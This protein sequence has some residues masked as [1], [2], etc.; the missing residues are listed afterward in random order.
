MK[1]TSSMRSSGGRKRRQVLA[2]GPIGGPRVGFEVGQASRKARDRVVIGTQPRRELVPR[3]RHGDRRLWRS[4]RRERGD[5]GR[6]A[7]VPQVVDEDLALSFRLG[8]TGH[9]RLGFRVLDVLGQTAGI[10][11]ALVRGRARAQRHDDVQPFAAGGLQEALEPDRLWTL[12]DQARCVGDAA[13]LDAGAGVEIEHDAVR[14]LQVL[15][16]RMPRV[17]FEYSD[18][19][20]A[21]QCRERIDDEIFPGLGLFLDLHPA[22]GFGSPGPAVLLIEARSLR[23]LGTADERR[24]TILQVGQDPLRDALVEARQVELGRALRWKEDAVGVREP[25]AG[26]DRLDRRRD[27]LE[28]S[29]A[30][31]A[32]GS[33]LEHVELP[34]R[35]R[36]TVAMLDQEPATLIAPVPTSAADLREHP[37]TVELRSLERELQ[38]ANSVSR[39]WVSLGPPGAAV[40]QNDRA[41][42]IL[43]CRD[44]ALEARV[45][46][47][48]ILHLHRQALVGG[49]EAWTLGDRPALEGAVELETEIVVQP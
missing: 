36:L 5:A 35:A 44:G 7:R 29:S 24:R 22:D 19:D 47:R 34:C 18:L 2:Q 26:D 10:G 14:S 40:P 9:V 33:R 45:L 28:S 38:R 48:V 12:A 42:A 27:L 43:A 3:E 17:D 20:E 41:R 31:D 37:A 32:L 6:A 30:R 11:E 46:E 25:H 16:D 13:P 23:T 15:H 49:I 1:S 8:H 21:D 39:L 4:A